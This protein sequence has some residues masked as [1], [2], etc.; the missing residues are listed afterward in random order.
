MKILI[1]NGPNLNLLGVRE[2]EIY[3]SR[4]FEEYLE[5]LRGKYKN[6][7][8]EYE[9]SNIEGE[10]IEKIHEAG[11]TCDGII[12]NAG[13]YTHTSVALADAVAAVTAPVVEV[14]ISNVARR[15]SFRHISFLSAVCVGTITGFGMNSYELGIQALLAR[16]EQ[17]EKK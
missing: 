7:N 12:L 1:L 5:Y 6:V 14:H 4:H 13:G 17:V 8:I 11:F 9:Q 2:P 3:G 15:E 10:L 16:K